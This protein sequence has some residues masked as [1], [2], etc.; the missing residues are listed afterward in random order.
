MRKIRAEIWFFDVMDK[1]PKRGRPPRIDPP[2]GEP[3]R[4]LLTLEEMITEIVK[5]YGIRNR[6]YIE[7]AEAEEKTPDL[8]PAEDE[9][10][11]EE[12]GEE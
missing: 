10:V 8:A 4:G 7:W 9:E 1:P 2:A 3:R 6:R 5:T 11:E 12:A